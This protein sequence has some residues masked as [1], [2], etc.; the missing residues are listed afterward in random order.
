MGPAKA[1]QDLKLE[2]FDITGLKVDVGQ[3]GHGVGWFWKLLRWKDTMFQVSVIVRSCALAEWSLE[4]NVGR[5]QFFSQL[6]MKPGWWRSWSTTGI[7]GT[8]FPGWKCLCLKKRHHLEFCSWLVVS[9]I[10]YFHPYLG[11]WSNLTNIFQMGWNHQLGRVLLFLFAVFCCLCFVPMIPML[12]FVNVCKIWYTW[13]MG[14]AKFCLC[15][16]RQGRWSKHPLVRSPTVLWILRYVMRS[17]MIGHGNPWNME[18]YFLVNIDLNTISTST[19]GKSTSKQ[20]TSQESI[21]HP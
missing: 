17:V 21:R 5:W 4:A 10:F 2:A 16:R 9:N 1:G 7:S 19:C 20:V 12:F 15:K 13:D 18:L 11:K 8:R 14:C 3:L 6:V